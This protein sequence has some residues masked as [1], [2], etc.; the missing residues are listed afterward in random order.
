MRT[1]S[2]VVWLAMVACT[3]TPGQKI[4][5]DSTASDSGMDAG[6]DGSGTG[7]DGEDSGADTADSADTGSP[8]DLDPSCPDLTIRQ[9]QVW[10]STASPRVGGWGAAVG[11]LDADGFDDVVLATRGAARVLLGG[12][13]GLTLAAPTLEDGSALPPGSSA[14]LA[15]LDNDGDLD[16]FLGTEP[17]EPDYLLFQVS[18]LVFRAEALADSDGFTGTGLFADLD[19]DGRLDL[20]VGRRLG[21]GETIED[22]L[23]NRSAGDPSSL[24]LQRSTGVFSDASDRLPDEIHDAH[25]QAVGALD[26]DGDGDL[27]LF[28]ANDFGPYIVPDQL[29]LNDGTGRF[30][31][32]TDCFCSLSHYG[33]SAAVADFDRD[34]HP[35]LYV[36]D[37]GGPELLANAGDGTFYDAALAWNASLPAAEDQLVAWGVAPFDVDRDG[38]VDLPVAFGVIAEVQRESIGELDP[39]WTWSDD[40]RDALLLGGPDGFTRVGAE[41]GFDDPAGHRAVVRGDFDGDARDEILLT[42]LSHTSVWD[43]EGG[44]PESLRVTLDG[45]PGNREGIGARVVVTVRGSVRTAWMLPAGTGSASASVVE[46]GL[47]EEAVVD[48]VEVVWPDGSSTIE[49]NVSSGVLHVAR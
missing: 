34:H 40:Q 43:I 21:A 45:G 2:G 8:V 6:G 11:D 46:M 12:S 23:A 39:S 18:P 41:L 30:T 28:F 35:D 24:Y 32:S 27:D 36:T 37:I 44:C 15:D 13:G 9:T 16:L 42:S 19:G 29:L 48:S 5:T 25:T 31:V 49:T 38:W 17:G 7:S 20:V 10:D 26:A 1:A 33:M 22:I 3:G 4:G 47:G 14:A